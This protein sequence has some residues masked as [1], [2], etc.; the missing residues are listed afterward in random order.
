MKNIFFTKAAL[1]V[2]CLSLCLTMTGCKKD[3]EEVSSETEVVTET[4]TES[5][6]ET[7]ASSTESEITSETESEKTSE[8]ETEIV[9]KET[10]TEVTIEAKNLTIM[11]VNLTGVDLGGFAYINPLTDEQENTGSFEDGHSY[12]L[13]LVWPVE[14]EEFEW[15][16]YN[17]DG[18]LAIEGSSNMTEAVNGAT[19]VINGD[20]EQVTDVSVDFN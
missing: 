17:M 20:G 3:A 5:E 13:D 18:K 6:T 11:I 7:A 16:L 10:E 8:V 15:A 14:K 2:F 9:T 12:T 19:I 4:A 1:A